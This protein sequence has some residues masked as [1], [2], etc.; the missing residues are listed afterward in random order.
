MK[1]SPS[2]FSYV[3]TAS[4]P[5]QENFY[6]SPSETRN[7]LR[8]HRLSSGF[9]LKPPPQSIG[10]VQLSRPSLGRHR[11]NHRSRLKITSAELP[12]SASYDENQTAFRRNSKAGF[13]PAFA[14]PGSR[15]KPHRSRPTKVACS[16]DPFYQYTEMSEDDRPT[17]EG[18]PDYMSI[19]QVYAIIKEHLI[20]G[21]VNANKE[22]SQ[23]RSR[24]Q[25][26]K[27]D[28]NGA[29]L[30]LLQ[31]AVRYNEHHKKFEN[32]EAPI[33]SKDLQKGFQLLHSKAG[34]SISDIVHGAATCTVDD[35]SVT[36]TS[37]NS[38]KF[39]LEQFDKNGIFRK[40]ASPEV[41][42]PQLSSKDVAPARLKPLFVGQHHSGLAPSHTWETKRSVSLIPQHEHSRS[43][44]TLQSVASPNLQSPETPASQTLLQSQYLPIPGYLQQR[45]FSPLPLAHALPLPTASNPQPPNASSTNENS[46]T[47]QANNSNQTTQARRFALPKLVIVPHCAS[48]SGETEGSE[49]ESGIKEDPT[50]MATMNTYQFEIRSERNTNGNFGVPSLPRELDVHRINLDSSSLGSNGIR[51]KY[52]LNKPSSVTIT[53]ASS[54]NMTNKM[55]ANDVNNVEAAQDAFSA[56]AKAAQSTTPPLR[57]T[58]A[59]AGVSRGLEDSYCEPCKI[60]IV[61]PGQDSG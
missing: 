12:R 48:F 60:T 61:F 10:E 18:D 29:P 40:S 37:E 31:L 41:Q 33:R 25:K 27:S 44:S 5:T 22:E 13:L 53:S 17:D 56:S 9:A 54:S 30:S 59:N 7:Q 21:S 14:P 42:Q 11:Q 49:D 46:S 6:E 38:L 26:R 19:G 39:R 3:I 15:N 43:F 2:I 52:L 34:R 51:M 24:E 35:S 4:M 1:A 47:T 45:V 36:K 20:E 57:Q 50:K 28:M 8:L 32:E 16:L 55:V 23:L 58:S